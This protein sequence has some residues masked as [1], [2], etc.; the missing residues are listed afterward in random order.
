MKKLWRRTH[1]MH[2][3]LRTPVYGLFTEGMRPLPGS[4]VLSMVARTTRVERAL[5]N[6][7]VIRPQWSRQCRKPGGVVCQHAMLC[8]LI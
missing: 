1:E 2:I 4:L 5:G 8:G 7:A 6:P 3:G